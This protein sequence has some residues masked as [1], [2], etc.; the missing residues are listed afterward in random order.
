[1]AVL[2][3]ACSG[4][5]TVPATAP[6]TSAPV[7]TVPPTTSDLPT[8][9]QATTTTTNIIDRVSE[10]EAIL[11]DI[12]LGVRQA[13]YDGDEA[14]FS[15]FYVSNGFFDRVL[16]SFLE[17]RPEV[18]PTWARVQVLDVYN[19]D[20]NCIAVRAENDWD[21]GTP[22]GRDLVQVLERLPNGDWGISFIGK[23]WQC[24]GPHPLP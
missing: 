21:G 7:S 3:A 2:F 12:E 16:P 18:R 20:E 4:G 14:A 10:I 11:E 17:S 13:A 24:V 23:G 1:M 6:P 5:D 8:T 22:Y 9:S 19:D 15:R